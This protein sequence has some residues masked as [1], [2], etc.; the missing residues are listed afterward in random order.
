M[1]TA[2]TFGRSFLVA[3]LA[4]TVFPQATRINFEKYLEVKT[5]LIPTAGKGLFST[6]FIPKGAYLGHY[7]GTFISEKEHWKLYRENR[8]HYVMRL[9]DCSASFTGGYTR[10]DGAN[11]NMFSRMNYA[12]KELQNV[13]FKKICFF[14]Y[15]KVMA[16]RDI[17]PGE[18]LYVDYGPYYNYDFMDN[19]EVVEFF[20][21]KSGGNRKVRK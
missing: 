10:I 17:R 16:T 21:K 13:R 11:G 1:N 3:I 5:S 15:V 8:W 6:V 18:E 19:K 14:P 2:L 7:A 12:H 20:T 9:D 4:L